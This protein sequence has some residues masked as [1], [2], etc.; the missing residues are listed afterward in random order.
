MTNEI[1]KIQKCILMRS[2]IQIWLNEERIKNLITLINS[3]KSKLVEIDG[4]Y[5]NT[6]DISGIFSAEEI[7][8]LTRRKNGQ[9]KCKWG[10]WHDKFKKCDCV[11]ESRAESDRMYKKLY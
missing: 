6:A 9:W 7:E 8:D 3:D 10:N 2:G 1:T 4:D 5:I 11:E